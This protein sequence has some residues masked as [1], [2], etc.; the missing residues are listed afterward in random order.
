MN[1]A[2]LVGTVVDDFSKLNSLS[3]AGS[4]LIDDGKELIK[5]DCVRILHFE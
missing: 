3:S 5:R 1:Y 2:E 4:M